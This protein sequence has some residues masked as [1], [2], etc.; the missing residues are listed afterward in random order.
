MDNSH[1]CSFVLR[2]VILSKYRLQGHQTYK[3]QTK[4]ANSVNYNQKNHLLLYLIHSPTHKLLTY[5]DVQNAKRAQSILTLNEGISM[6]R[7]TK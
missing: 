2:S 1:D 3:V 4:M 6:C 5:E 7:L